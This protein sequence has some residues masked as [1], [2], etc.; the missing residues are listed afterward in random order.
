MLSIKEKSVVATFEYTDETYKITGD[1]KKTALGVLKESSMS[2][3]KISDGSTVGFANAYEEG[4]EIKY[5]LAGVN[6]NDMS[7][8]A[9]SVVAC[10]QEIHDDDTLS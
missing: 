4:S 1:F 5:N 8:V 3:F 2:I 9:A 6:L 10:A 7:A